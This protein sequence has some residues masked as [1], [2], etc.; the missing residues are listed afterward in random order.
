MGMRLAQSGRSAA[1]SF[2]LFLD[3]GGA[4]PV[5]R[6]SLQGPKAVVSEGLG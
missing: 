6:M 3:L 5:L 2:R 4:S 1:G